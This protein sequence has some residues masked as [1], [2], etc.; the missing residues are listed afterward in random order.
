MNV[1]LVDDDTGSLLGMKFAIEMMGYTCDDCLSPL[2][3][4]EKYLPE[5]HDVAVIDYQ[6]PILNGFKVLQKMRSKNPALKAII[7][8]GCVDIKAETEGQPY[9]LLKKPLGDDF[10]QALKEIEISSRQAGTTLSLQENVE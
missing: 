6:M 10:F 5:R 7:I 8:S 1:L 2:E 9:I 3:A 4:I